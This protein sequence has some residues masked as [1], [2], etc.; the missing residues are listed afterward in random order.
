MKPFEDPCETFGGRTLNDKEIA[1]SD[2]SFPIASQHARRVP[3]SSSQNHSSNIPGSDA[4]LYFQNVMGALSTDPHNSSKLPGSRTAGEV[5]PARAVR[6]AERRAEA[7]RRANIKSCGDHHTSHQPDG[8]K[9]SV[10]NDVCQSGRNHIREKQRLLSNVQK[11][12]S[13]A[14]TAKRLYTDLVDCAYCELRA[15]TDSGNLV[16][17][18]DGDRARDVCKFSRPINESGPSIEQASDSRRGVASTGNDEVCGRCHVCQPQFISRDSHQ[19][20]MEYAAPS[21]CRDSCPCGKWDSCCILG[22]ILCLLNQP[23]I[24]SSSHCFFELHLVQLWMEMF[25]VYQMDYV[26][27]IVHKPCG[28]PEGQ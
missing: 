3:V 28:H 18:Q 12:Q 20:C 27:R 22:I 23:C 24:S 9:K 6:R 1:S 10:K 16:K 5:S 11:L 4:D 7:A 13:V 15:S 21:I 19:E 8:I 17:H 14:E 25:M 26:V 2:S